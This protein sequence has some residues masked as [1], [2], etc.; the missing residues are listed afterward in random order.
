MLYAATC[1]QARGQKWCLCLH[2]VHTLQE[3]EYLEIITREFA[4][5]IKASLCRGT[6][7]KDQNTNSSDVVLLL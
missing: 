1:S 4:K 3:G 5:A 7:I 2:H 6:V